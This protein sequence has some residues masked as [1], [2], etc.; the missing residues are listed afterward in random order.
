MALG[1]D[2]RAMWMELGMDLEK[3][4]EFMAPLPQVYSDIFVSQPNRPAKMDYYG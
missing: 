3:H 2:Y 1:I 4:D